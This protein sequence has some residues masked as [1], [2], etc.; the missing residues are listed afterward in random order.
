MDAVAPV[1]A[2]EGIRDIKSDGG[3]VDLRLRIKQSLWDGVKKVALCEKI[4]PEEAVVTALVNLTVYG[5]KD[6]K[7]SSYI[8]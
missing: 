6:E 3:Y 2:G 4:K 1:Y 8:S 5:A 7:S